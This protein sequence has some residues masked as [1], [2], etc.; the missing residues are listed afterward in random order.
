MDLDKARALDLAVS[1]VD[2]EWKSLTE[3]DITVSILRYSLAFNSLPNCVI[4][5]VKLSSVVVTAADCTLLKIF[6]KR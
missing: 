6:P 2:D 1:F 3:D 5:N 4:G